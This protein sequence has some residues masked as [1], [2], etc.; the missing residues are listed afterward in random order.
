MPINPL[1][2][3][4]TIQAFNWENFKK[5]FLKLWCLHLVYVTRPIAQTE[6]SLIA[7]PVVKNS[8]PAKSYTFVEVDH[9]THSTIILA[10]GVLSICVQA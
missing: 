3:A 8:I 5:S 9:E 2:V 1:S 6:M 4:P 7:D 10:Q